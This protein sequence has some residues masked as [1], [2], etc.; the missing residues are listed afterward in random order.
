MNKT[1]T[2]KEIY[3]RYQVVSTLLKKDE[4]LFEDMLTMLNLGFRISDDTIKLYDYH[5]LYIGDLEFFT[6]FKATGAE[7]ILSADLQLL[8]DINVSIKKDQEGIYR[9]KTDGMLMRDI[10]LA[11]SVDEKLLNILYRDKFDG[12]SYDLTACIQKD[13]L[14]LVANTNT[15]TRG[16]VINDKLAMY[17][18]IDKVKQNVFKVQLDNESKLFTKIVKDGQVDRKTEID[19]SLSNKDIISSPK[20]QNLV[21][22]VVGNLYKAIPGFEEYV[23]KKHPEFID[24]IKPIETSSKLDDHIEKY[25]LN[26]LK[27][28]NEIKC[29]QKKLDK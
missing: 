4:Q 7:P 13:A 8:N 21:N 14:S 5:N 19:T 3:D 27:L 23:N 20:A 18:E 26:G 24:N 1:L 11:T 12:K 6:N 22:F 2:P 10:E 25:S 15:F 28:P 17:Y 16:L 9:F 29:K